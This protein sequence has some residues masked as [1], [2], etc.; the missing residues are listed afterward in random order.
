[1]SINHVRL[2]IDI[3][4]LTQP[5]ENM[6]IITKGFVQAALQ[7]KAAFET[8]KANPEAVTSNRERTGAT[9]EA[10]P[11][12]AKADPEVYTPMTNDKMDNF[13]SKYKTETAAPSSM[14]AEIIGTEGNDHLIGTEEGDSIS[15][16]GGNDLISGLGGNDTIFGG[17]GRDTILGDD[18]DDILFGQMGNDLIYGGNGNDLID[19][20]SGDYNTLVGGEG[21]DD[22]RGVGLLMGG[23]GSDKLFG[24]GKLYGGEG[25][26]YINVY[27][28]GTYAS[29]GAGNDIITLDAAKNAQVYGGLG[30]DTIGTT[31]QS[32]YTNDMTV[33]YKNSNESTRQSPDLVY[34][35]EKT[36]VDLSAMGNQLPNGAKAQWVDTFTAGMP[37]QFKLGADQLEGDMDGDGIAEFFVKLIAVDAKRLGNDDPKYVVSKSQFILPDGKPKSSDKLPQELPKDIGNP[38]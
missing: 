24:S 21:N 38:Q 32:I 11:M 10:E 23:N 7:E 30:S 36:K 34:M 12:Q 20:T 27:G 8:A 2:Q 1:M 15:G 14:L 33:L 18:G 25:N 26:D 19:D 6:G 28:D 37:G 22:I 35:S 9:F 13:E 29:G 5:S 16:L 17:D 4:T 3:P 31:L